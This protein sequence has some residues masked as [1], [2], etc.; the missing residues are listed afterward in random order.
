[1]NR[2]GRLTKTKIPWRRRL[3][4]PSG[5]G[6]LTAGLEGLVKEA[7]YREELSDKALASFN[8]HFYRSGASDQ[9]ERVVQGM[10]L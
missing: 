7:S 6:A 9:D 1:M 4:A 2:A 8:D 3:L 10:I 5:P